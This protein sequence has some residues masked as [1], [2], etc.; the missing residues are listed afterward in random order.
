MWLLQLNLCLR[1]ASSFCY[2]VVFITIF[3]KWK[4]KWVFHSTGNTS[5]SVGEEKQFNPRLTKPKDEFIE[6]MNNLGLPYPKKIG[7]LLG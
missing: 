5:S 4:G 6:I 7:K 3:N 2:C 1:I